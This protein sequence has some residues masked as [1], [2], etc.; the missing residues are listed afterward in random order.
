MWI[1]TDIKS[2]KGFVLL[3]L[4]KIGF[5]G[6]ATVSQHWTMGA[7]VADSFIISRPWIGWKREISPSEEPFTHFIF[8]TDFIRAKLCCY[9]MQWRFQN[10]SDE[11]WHVSL[12]KQCSKQR[13]LKHCLSQ[14]LLS[15]TKSWRRLCGMWIIWCIWIH[16]ITSNRF[17]PY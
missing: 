14:C 13:N 6:A 11:L 16:T 3:I 15:F 4:S 9:D 12:I 10:K 2:L 7:A 8:L 1:G 17:C 5:R